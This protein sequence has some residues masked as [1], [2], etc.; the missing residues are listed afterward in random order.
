MDT[1]DIR[2]QDELICDS[3]YEDPSHQWVLP[4]ANS[5]K[6]SFKMGRVSPDT[7]CRTYNQVGSLTHSPELMSGLTIITD[8]PV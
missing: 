5:T 2:P 8:A 6:T 4:K 3:V 1:Q 7:I